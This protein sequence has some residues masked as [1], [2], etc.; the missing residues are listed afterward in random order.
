MDLSKRCV[1]VSAVSTICLEELETYFSRFGNVDQVYV[2]RD[3]AVFVV[4]ED[5]A[6][7]ASAVRCT[8]LSFMENMWLI[9]VPN[10]LELDEL[11]AIVG[12][13]GQHGV[14]RLKPSDE[15]NAPDVGLAGRQGVHL[16]SNEPSALDDVQRRVRTCVEGL[17]PA[18]LLTILEPLVRD[19]EQHIPSR[20][21]S[22]YGSRTLYDEKVDMPT[23]DRQ[24]TSARVTPDGNL[25]RI[26]GSP[27]SLLGATSGA[28]PKRPLVDPLTSTVKRGT[29]PS[30]LDR[31]TPASHRI[32]RTVPL[33]L[34]FSNVRQHPDHRHP[35]ST[36]VVAPTQIAPSQPQLSPPPGFAPF[37]SLQY[38]KIIFFSGDQGKDAS[39]QQWRN[40]VVCLMNEGHPTPNI[41]Q[42]IRRSLKGTAAD[43]LLNTGEDTTPQKI[44]KK[45]DVIFGDAL[46]S[47][48]LLEEY[49]TARQKEGE[50]AA[51]WGCRLESVMN[52][53]HRRGY[54]SANIA[55]MLRTKFWSG[56][57]DERVKN[58][59]RH[60]F[61]ANQDFVSLL[62][63]ARCVEVESV[64]DD[65]P[66]AQKPKTNHQT[67]KVNVQQT[68]TLESR[69]ED[70]L[71]EMS[72]MRTEFR[73][74]RQREPT[75]Q[76]DERAQLRQRLR[77]TGSCFYCHDPGHFIADCT[78]R[79]PRPSNQQPPPASGNGQ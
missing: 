11:Y 62:H 54:L 72:A 60:K 25:D 34:P 50:P 76:M 65:Q 39:Y 38:P 7:V 59:I 70:L 51:V 23:E 2:Y 69:F 9:G 22:H 48:A 12:D 64:R 31:F 47:E 1:I 74:F 8:E 21:A 66:D 52:K 29:A 10:E 24:P 53:V 4:F 28:I 19:M 55:E 73:D 35:T 17:A 27:Y 46:S 14:R 18:D 68:P 63:A 33:D 71:R 36:P 58:A 37:Q 45:F 5:A 67:A 79:P 78:K 42:G 41:L 40:E 49:Y 3:N 15:H 57:R 61:D 20:S 77:S 43:A 75:P 6:S 26:T 30:R 16:V 32:N 56:L 13:S 44:V